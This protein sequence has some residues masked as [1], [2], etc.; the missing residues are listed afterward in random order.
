MPRR[1]GAV[2]FRDDAL[3]QVIALKEVIPRGFGDLRHAA[4][5]AGDHPLEQSGMVETPGAEPLTVARTRTHDQRQIT[6]LCALYVTLL[7][8]GVERFWNA[9]LNETARGDDIVV[10]D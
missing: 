3:W 8:G 4:E 7:Q 1:T 2:E 10:A 6:R 9:A 5:I